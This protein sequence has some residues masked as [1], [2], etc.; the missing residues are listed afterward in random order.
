MKKLITVCATL[1]VMGLT[2][3]PAHSGSME[4]LI[5]GMS[6]ALICTFYCP[7]LGPAGSLL[8]TS[9]GAAL[10]NS[11]NGAQKKAYAQAILNDTQNF[12]LDG[13][14]SVTLKGLLDSVQDGS[15]EAESID[16]LNA[17]AQDLMGK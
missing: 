13:S 12:Y 1:G 15:S 11:L 5:A 14:V 9:T 3:V 4:G 10:T 8:A 2:S 7:A 16:A 6:S 17:Y